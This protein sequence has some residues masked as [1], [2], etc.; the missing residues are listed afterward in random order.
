MIFVGM[1]V[2]YKG[3]FAYKQYSIFRRTAQHTG[4][5]HIG[6]RPGAA[7]F[8]LLC[9]PRKWDASQHTIGIYAEKK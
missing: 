3:L 9:N 8:G 6:E 2:L 5:V 1:N 4:C 7:S